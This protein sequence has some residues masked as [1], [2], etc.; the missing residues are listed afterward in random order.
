MDRL[1]NLLQEKTIIVQ[2]L[3]R[4]RWQDV[5]PRLRHVIVEALGKELPA[6]KSYPKKGTCC[7]CGGPWSAECPQRTWATVLEEKPVTGDM[8]QLVDETN[9]SD[10]SGV[11]FHLQNMKNHLLECDVVRHMTKNP[12]MVPCSRTRQLVMGSTIRCYPNV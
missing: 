2:P 5:E 4:K 6:V 9:R 3:S 1:T 7:S 12:H 10:D 8:L 11:H